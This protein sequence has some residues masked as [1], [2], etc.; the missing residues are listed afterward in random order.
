MAVEGGAAK[1]RHGWTAQR[2]PPR[3]ITDIPGGPPTPRL[4]GGP[5]P[6]TR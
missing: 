3:H 6:S 1:V 2:K 5:Q 4:R